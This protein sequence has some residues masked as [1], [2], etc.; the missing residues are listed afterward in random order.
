MGWHNDVLNEE[1]LPVSVLKRDEGGEVIRLRH[2]TLGKDIV[3]ISYRGKSDAYKR[4]MT[5]KNSN[6][7]TV[8]DVYEENGTTVSDVLMGGLYTPKGTAAVC[9]G[10]C[11][12]LYALH[13][14]NIIHRDVKPENVM[15]ENAGRVVLIDLDASR[16]YSDSKNADTQLM[17]TVGYAAPEQFGFLQTGVRADIFSVGVL[18]NVMLTGEHPSKKLYG[19]KMR[20]IIEKCIRLDPDERY[21]DVSE[22]K[23]SLNKF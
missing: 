2:K 8:Y 13:S 18:M 15:I 5:V 14:L 17:G 12:A 1:Y 4:L 23:L 7:P 19:G 21:S 9:R 20:K 3:K 10:V 11:D 16:I 6:L 22:L